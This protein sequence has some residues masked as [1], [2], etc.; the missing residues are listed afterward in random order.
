VD[1]SSMRNTGPVSSSRCPSFK[2]LGKRISSHDFQ[3]CATARYILLPDKRTCIQID[4]S[5]DRSPKS[6]EIM[7]IG[8]KYD[9]ETWRLS[10]I[11]YWSHEVEERSNIAKTSRARG[12][13]QKHALTARQ[14]EQDRETESRWPWNPST[15]RYQVTEKAG[16]SNK[17]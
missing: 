16:R 14:K 1:P 3:E 12:K 6:K 4:R 7:G 15:S 5:I 10:T 17:R 11:S 9:S 13:S 8:A 2:A